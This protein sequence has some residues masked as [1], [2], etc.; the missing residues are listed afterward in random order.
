V[1]RLPPVKL[2]TTFQIQWLGGDGQVL[3]KSRLVAVPRDIARSISTITSDAT[4]GILDPENRVKPL[5]K[6]QNSFIRKV[7]A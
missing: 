5:F 1:V 3:G 7:L 6:E 2:A 4:T